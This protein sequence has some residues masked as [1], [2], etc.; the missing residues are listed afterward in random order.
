MTPFPLPLTELLGKYGA[1]FIFLLIGIGFGFVLES[2]GFGNSKKLAAQFYF[3]DMTVLKVMF[4]SIVTAMVLIFGAS[5]LGLLDYNLVWVNPTYLWPGIIGGLIMGVGFIIGGFCPGTSL[6]A[7]ATWKLDGIFFALGV[8][9]GIFIF[10]ETVRSIDLFWNSSYMGRFTIMDW[11]GLSTGWV[12]LI[13]VLMA[14]FM[15]WGSE[16]LEKIFG[17]KD[18]RKAPKFR[19]VGAGA[20]ALGALLLIPLGQPTNADKWEQVSVEKEAQLVNREVQISPAELLNTI[21][22]HPINLIMLDVRDESNY[23]IFHLADARQVP[24]DELAG[25][26][27]ELHLEPENTVIVLMSNDETAATQAWRYLV[28]ESIPNV[29]IL[30][31]GIN[32]WLSV[33][34]EEDNRIMAVDSSPDDSLRFAFAAALGAAFPSADP[35]INEYDLEFIPKIKLELKRGPTSGGCG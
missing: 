13:I 28:A 18:P 33:F 30:E 3:K 6:V 10:G 20:L 8:I 1:Y 17:G 11:L 19:Y 4:G 31:G 26:T 21:H 23:N 25:I 2:S 16:Q 27:P 35:H 15:F 5:A 7:A 9:F 32:N 34:A 29:Y 22:D 24:F 14:L 12:V